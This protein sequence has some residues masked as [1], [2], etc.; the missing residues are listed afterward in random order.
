MPPDLAYLNG[1]LRPLSEPGISPLDYGFLYGYGLY[2]TMRAYGGRVFLLDNHLDRL[3]R[4]AVELRFGPIPEQKELAE[5]VRQTMAANQ[6]TEARV[7]LS[8][9]LGKGDMVPDPASCR[10]PVVLVMAKK[11]TPFAREVYRKGFRSILS[12][13]RR[14]SQSP[15]SRLKTANYLTSLLARVEVRARQADDGVLLNEK[16]MLT[17]CTSSNIFLINNDLLYTPTIESGL[18]PGITRQAVLE[19][20][21]AQGIGV[22]VEELSLETLKQAREAFITNSIMEIMPLT[23][24]EGLPIGNGK[25]GPITETLMEAYSHS[26]GGPPVERSSVG[27]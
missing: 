15:L 23:S 27:V 18:L 14:D 4:A 9:S 10:E 20:A 13:Y 26:T 17:E 5:A 22:R 8:V 3:S 19:L 25:P 16:D 12:S 24:F 11:Y 21:A 6:L 2:E 1:V 7:R